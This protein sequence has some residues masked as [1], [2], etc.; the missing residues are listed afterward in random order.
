MK[1]ELH[2]H[3]CLN[4]GSQRGVLIVIKLGTYLPRLDNIAVCIGGTY[5][6]RFSLSNLNQEELYLGASQTSQTFKAF[7]LIK[8]L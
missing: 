5:L 2:Y 4:V 8:K 6:P 1:G 7:F 3:R